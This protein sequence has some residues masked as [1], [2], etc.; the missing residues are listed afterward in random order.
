[1]HFGFFHTL[2]HYSVFSW[3]LVAPSPTLL[4]FC[5]WVPKRVRWS[6]NLILGKTF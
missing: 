2:K 5:F 1:L 3:R 4:T 6:Q